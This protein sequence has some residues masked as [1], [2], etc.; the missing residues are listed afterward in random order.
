ML[1]EIFDYSQTAAHILQYES[2]DYSKSSWDLEKNRRELIA[3]LKKQSSELPSEIDIYL[4]WYIFNNFYES[5]SQM[6]QLHKLVFGQSC[7]N[8]TDCTEVLEAVNE[9]NPELKSKLEILVD[10]PKIHGNMVTDYV[11]VPM[12]G[13]GSGQMS[14]CNQFE[15]NQFRYQDHQCFSYDQAIKAE[16]GEKQGFNFILNLKSMPKDE[17]LALKLFLHQPGSVPDV[18]GLEHRFEEIR[19]NDWTRIGIS[20]TS[21]EAT[22]NFKSMSE[23]KRNC[24]LSQNVSRTQCLAELV[25]KY[26]KNQCKCD[27][28]GFNGS[29]ICDIDGS[30]CFR[31][32]VSKAKID[33]SEC[34]IPCA[35]KEYQMSRSIDTWDNPFAL[36]Q[37]IVDFLLDNPVG[38]VLKNMTFGNENGPYGYEGLIREVWQSYSL[39]QIYLDKPQM[40]VITKD[41][42]V[43]LPDMISNIGG[44][45]GIFLGLSALSLLDLIIDWGSKLKHFFCRSDH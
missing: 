25:H 44:T 30:Y 20:I 18:L 15:P 43:T 42:K 41:A 22:A 38:L 39:V 40:T 13:F 7:Y 28:K 37:E 12:C 11:L 34:Q 17:P 35:Y 29:Q 3:Y 24:S 26:A 23:T 4:I 6:G 31:K 2:N 1:M 5:G 36:G 10:Q 8:A 33:R 19:E 16:V 21:N 27:P 45:I 9:I 32:A 14:K